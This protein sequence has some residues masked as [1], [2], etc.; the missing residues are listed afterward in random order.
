MNRDEW[1]W[2]SRL[3][4]MVVGGF[5]M[6]QG[7]GDAATWEAAAA[8]AVIVAGALWSRRARRK[9]RDKAEA[10]KTALDM[11]REMVGRR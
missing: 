5:L 11:A 6:N 9:L 7:I 4:M 2:A 3:G 1:L 10:G 8:L